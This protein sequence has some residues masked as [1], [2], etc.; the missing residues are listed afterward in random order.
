MTA[1]ESLARSLV[2]ASHVAFPRD[3]QVPVQG[4]GS[5]PEVSI[6]Y[7]RTLVLQTF[8]CLLLIL[9]KDIDESEVSKILL[10]IT[11]NFFRRIVAKFY[12]KSF[13][14]S[15]IFMYKCFFAVLLFFQKIFDGFENAFILDFR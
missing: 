1:V 14:F 4:S 6:I 8:K 13:L 11:L 5:T 15:A 2:L 9:N 12:D 10:N 7:D 3:T